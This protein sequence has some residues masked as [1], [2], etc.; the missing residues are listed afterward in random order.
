ML[1]SR[2]VMVS[3]AHGNGFRLLATDMNSITIRRLMVAKV[4]AYLPPRSLRRRLNT[5]IDT[6]AAK[7][8]KGA[9]QAHSAAWLLIDWHPA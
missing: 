3:A 7:A 9:F 1:C 4:L 5:L 6:A 8:M 2:L